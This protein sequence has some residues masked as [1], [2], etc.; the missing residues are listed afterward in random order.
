VFPLSFILLLILAIPFLFL[1]LNYHISELA[2]VKLGIPANLIFAVFILSLLGG[3]INIPIS[4]RK[5][6]QKDELPP[7]M[8]MFFYY[9][10]R[11]REQIIAIN[12]GGAIV[13]ILISIY[14]FKFAPIVPVIIATT[15]ITILTK[16]LARPVPGIGIAMPAFIPPIVAAVLAMLLAH[17]Q[18]PAAVAYISGVIGTLVGADLLNLNKISKMGGYVLSIGGA[19]VFDGIF[20]IGVIAALLA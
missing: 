18:N 17:N 7:L 1:V 16:F 11:M 12:V 6:T 20:L 3:L 4:K 13:P 2:F 9:P 10:P 8:S 14:L 5:I 19:G 15:I